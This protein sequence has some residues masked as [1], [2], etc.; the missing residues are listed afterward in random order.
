MVYVREDEEWDHEVG[1]VDEVHVPAWLV[2]TS[3]GG[4]PADA[5]LRTH[6]LTPS[7]THKEPTTT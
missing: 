1:F 4:Q 7:C 5:L 3:E 6:T 2:P